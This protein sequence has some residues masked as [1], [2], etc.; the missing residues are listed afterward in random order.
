M[1]I[2]YDHQIFTWQ[3]IGGISRYFVELTNNLP[4]EFVAKQSTLLTDNIYLSENSRSRNRTCSLL[5]GKSFRG[6]GKM[7]TLVNKTNTFRLL[8]TSN[9][10]V[11]HPTYYDPYFLQYNKKPYVITVYDM[12]HEKFADMF[13]ANDPTSE[14]KKKTVL[15]ADKVIAISKQTKQDLIELYGMDDEK[16]DVVY[17]GHSVDINSISEVEDLPSN[18][19]LYVGDRGGYKNFGTFLKAFAILT[20]D[21][22][23]LSLVCTGKNFTAEEQALI[24]SLHLSER[25]FRFFVSDSQL[26]YLY[27]KARCF[28]F[29]SLYEGFGIPILESFAAGCPIALSNTSCFPEIAQEGGIYFDPY[30]VDSMVH[31]LSTLLN[32]DIRREEQIARGYEVLKQYSWKK[33]AEETADVYRSFL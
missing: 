13:S 22:P 4:S 33:M 29:P 28:I 26:T 23:I 6:K 2:L 27:R 11:F 12:I 1:K 18:Y 5:P 20:H 14:Y 8:S 16:I 24:A 9:F 17:L 31:A 32:D 3:R 21:N 10:D 15:N 19:I 7:Y 30:N 25:V